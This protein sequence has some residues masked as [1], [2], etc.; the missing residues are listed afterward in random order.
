M[1]IEV[2]GFEV[3]RES[4]DARRLLE[5]AVL[6]EAGGGDPARHDESTQDT[7]S[8]YRHGYH[9]SASREP[10]GERRGKCA[11]SAIAFTR[12]R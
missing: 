11:S 9:G 12:K 6:R 10:R 8:R 4:D 3:R 2:V 7:P 1:A 5:C